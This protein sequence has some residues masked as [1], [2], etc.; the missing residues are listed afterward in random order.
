MQLVHQL[1]AVSG[2]TAPHAC[3]CRCEFSKSEFVEGMVRLGCDSL[4]KLQ[5]KLPA[6]REELR[7]EAKFRQIYDYAYM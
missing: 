5:K 1:A 3:S 2:F 4:E 7:D 6:L